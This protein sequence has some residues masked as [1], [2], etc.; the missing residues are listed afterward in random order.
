MDNNNKGSL[1]TKFLK[2]FTLCVVVFTLIIGTAT[3]T[4]MLINR[5]K[6]KE[7]SGDNLNVPSGQDTDESSQTNDG[8]AQEPVKQLTTFAIFGVDK[9]GYRTDVI[10]I[11]TLNHLNSEMNIVSIPRDTGVELPTDI[12]NDFKSRGKKVAKKI[13]INEVPSHSRV[14][15]RN[16]NSVKVIE[17]IFDIDVDYYVKVDLSAFRGLVDIVGPIEFHVPKALT[18]KDPVQD[19]YVNIEA[20]TQ[21]FNGAKAEQLIRWRKDNNNRGYPDGDIGRI[22]VQHDFMVAVLEKVL[23]ENNKK[24][25][26][27]I[28]TLALAKVDTDFD[29]LMNYLEHIQNLSVDKIEFH[30]LQGRGDVSKFFEYDK[31]ETAKLFEAITTVEQPETTPAT[32]DTGD[33]DPE[34]TTPDQPE[35]ISS[36]GLNIQILNGAGKQGLAGRTQA[37]LESDGYTVSSIGNH[38]AR[39]QK[40][41]IIIPNEGMGEDLAAYFSEPDIALQPENLPE[42]VDI[43]IIIGMADQSAY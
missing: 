16:Q 21:P 14:E 40:T 37:K 20:G 11:A 34:E 9:D 25:L 8:E 22:K 24:N 5:S 38:N 6:A 2:V 15:E 31:E 3:G 4:Y 42:G 17:E 28:G 19:F 10:M 23:N 32:D 30:S 1:L 18:Y 7:V 43:V 12:Y 13:K 29:Q 35:P 26:L 33:K 36:K 39:P 27:R 41:K